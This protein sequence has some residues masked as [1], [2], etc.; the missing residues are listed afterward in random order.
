MAGPVD[1]ITVPKLEPAAQLRLHA[2]RILASDALGRSQ[3]LEPLFRYLLACSL[4]GRTP[5]ELEVADEVFGRSAGSLDQ[6]ASIRVHIHRLRR[7]LDEYYAGP[8]AGEAERLII[9]KADYR[10]TITPNPAFD[11][12]PQAVGLPRSLGLRWR[13]LAAVASLL[14]CTAGATWWLAAR[15]DPV[16]APLIS[17]RA[18]PLWH[19][20]IANGRRI[21]LVVGD[22]YIFGERDEQ[23]GITR[24]V[25]EFDVNSPRDLEHRIA[26]DPGRAGNYIDLDLDYLPVGVGNAL[27]VISPILRRNDRAVVPTMV[28][29]ASKL[30]PEMVK[31]TNLVYLGYLSGLGSLRDPMFSGSR[32]AIGS[33]YDEIIDRQ[34]GHHY[35]AA[36]HLDPAGAD[37]GQDYALI[38]CFSGVSGNRV[39]VIAGTRDAAL[40]QAAEFAA[41]PD[42]LAKLAQ[43]AQGAGSFDALLAVEGLGNVG[44]RARLVTVAKRSGETDWS[45]ASRQAF[46]D[47]PSR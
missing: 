19:P 17:A 35:V 1:Q 32:F 2:D 22:Y 30:G 47:E 33:S 9:P 31:L 40:M 27:R 25:R 12:S 8:G 10:L 13:E 38:S 29:P 3:A 21:A 20:V 23:G 39:V 5:K 43:A 36:T 42:M 14:V 41:Q 44:L 37:P 16:E 7:K 45:G 24:L 28:V 26:S 18:S 4:E 34:T 46:P 11:T 6:D 15:P